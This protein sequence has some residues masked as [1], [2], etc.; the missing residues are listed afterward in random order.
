M[1]GVPITFLNRYNPKQ[2]E[3]IGFFNN[4]NP[5]TASIEKGQIYGN[6]VKIQTVNSLFRGPVVNGK[7]VYFRVLIK[8]KTI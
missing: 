5:K 3:I 2:F 4:Y 6:A 7:A 1:M 8:N